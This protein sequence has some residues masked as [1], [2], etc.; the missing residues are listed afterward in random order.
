[1]FKRSRIAAP[2]AFQC[3][4]LLLAFAVF[5]WG[6]QYKLSLYHASESNNAPAKLLTFKSNAEAEIQQTAR[7]QIKP[8]LLELQTGFYALLCGL[9]LL[10]LHIFLLQRPVQ[11]SLRPQRF[12]LNYFAFRPPPYIS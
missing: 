7:A 1:M 11:I 12:S 10:G 2:F 4:L 9:S 3:A 5:N 8:V 6:L